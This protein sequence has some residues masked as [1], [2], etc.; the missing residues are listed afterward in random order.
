WYTQYTPYQAEIAQGRLE[1][2][3]NFQTMVADLTGLPLAGAS[4]LD[5]ATAVAESMHMCQA[6]DR[7]NRTQ[8]FLSSRCHPESIAV[9]RTRAHPL[10]IEVIVGDEETASFDGCMGV[11]VQYPGTDGVVL[12]YAKVVEKAHAAGA[13]VVVATDLLALT[14]LRSPGE[15]GADIAVGTSQRFGVPLG[16]GGPHAAFLATRDEF[17]RMMPG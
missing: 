13:L 3:V 4:L 11:V 17:K 15:L 9:V 7:K 2:L 10:G 6:A 5:E 16:Y 1:A 12:D 8:F 14:M